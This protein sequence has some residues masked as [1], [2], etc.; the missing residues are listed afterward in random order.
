V[1]SQLL[2][3]AFTLYTLALLARVISYWVPSFA[4]SALIKF[5]IPFTDPYLALFKR[6]IPPIG[7]TI[8]ISPLLA[9]IALQIAERILLAIL[10][11]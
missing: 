7:G 11:P 9:F 5:I 3:I 8:D 4:S 1:L 2:R 10:P 6:L